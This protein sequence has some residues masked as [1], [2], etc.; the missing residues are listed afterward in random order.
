VFN[1]I[2]TGQATS[3][4]TRAPSDPYRAAGEVST[5]E[6]ASCHERFPAS[7]ALQGQCRTCTKSMHD[8]LAVLRAQE[9]SARVYADVQGEQDRRARNARILRAVL[10]IAAAIVFGLIRY[11][12]RTQ[13]RE[14]LRQSHGYSS[15][16]G[17]DTP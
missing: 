17:E 12:M 1:E 8:P 10:L 7:Q 9:Q 14:D 2:L 4:D 15:Y 6:C 11:G 3:G 5:L 16:Q 13:L